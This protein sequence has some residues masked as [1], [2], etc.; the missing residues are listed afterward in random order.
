MSMRIALLLSGLAAWPGVVCPATAQPAPIEVREDTVFSRD[1]GTLRVGDDGVAFD[2]RDVKHSRHWTFAEVRQLRIASS[3]RIIVETYQS[4]GWRGLGHSQTHQYRTAAPVPPEWVADVLSRITRS[5]V[6]SVI[7]PA[8]APARFTIDVNHEGTDTGGRLALYSEGLAFET[9]RDGFA[10]F[11]RFADLDAVLLQ[12][13]YRLLVAAYE[14]S[15]EHV[16]PFLFTLKHELS[17]GFYD[18]L[19]RT[20]N[21]RSGTTPRMRK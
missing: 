14:G 5:V 21:G 9:T 6:T 11:W 20:V 10:R 4:R 18:E 3:R 12:D 17:P 15:R 1:R 7:P 19:W 13:R 16:R 8:A 2:A